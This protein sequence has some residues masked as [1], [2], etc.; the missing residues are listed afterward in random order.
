[1]DAVVHAAGAAASGYGLT[2]PRDYIVLAGARFAFGHQADAD[3][4]YPWIAQTLAGPS[5]KRGARL[6]QRIRAYMKH[7][8]AVLEGAA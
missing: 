8:V 4:L 2:T 5:E 3:P 1:V 6:H 7:M